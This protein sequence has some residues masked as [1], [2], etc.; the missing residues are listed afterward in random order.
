MAMAAM[1]ISAV[2]GLAGSLAQA[3]ALNA[4]AKAQEQIAE[5]NAAQQR[6]E[7]NRRQAEGAARA[8]QE[9][10]NAQS[11]AGK[12]RAAF[13][14]IGV[15]TTQGSPLLLEQDL[16]KEG[17]YRSNIAVSDA[18][19]EQRNLQEAAKA[20]IYEGKIRAMASRSQAAA[21]ILGGIGS[22]FSALSKVSFG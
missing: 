14:Q 16:T 11:L 12:A 18:A 9:E 10:R 20:T 17:A 7:A 4:Q 2:A 3:S 8:F 22:A 13:A 6:I 15:D 1:L 5:F 21:S 19:N